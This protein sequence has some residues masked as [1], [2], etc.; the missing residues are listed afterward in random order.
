MNQTRQGDFLSGVTS[1][2]LRT[3]RARIGVLLT[4]LLAETDL[5]LD[6]F[7]SLSLSSFN[8]FLGVLFSFYSFY[9]KELGL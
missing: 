7:F 6:L 4:F 5:D 8:S 9:L 1:R 2:C 3:G